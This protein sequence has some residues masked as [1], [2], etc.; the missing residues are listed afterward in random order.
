MR[1]LEAVPTENVV[2]FGV[3]GLTDAHPWSAGYRK[4]DES[5]D[6]FIPGIRI[7]PTIHH[8]DGRSR[9]DM[10]VP[11]AALGTRKANVR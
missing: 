11:P 7:A 2:H 9:Q 3:C 5:P 6:P 8:A 10:L 1:V 4:A